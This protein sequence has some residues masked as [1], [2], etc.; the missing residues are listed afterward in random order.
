MQSWDTNSSVQYRV[1]EEPSAA[2]DLYKWNF[3]VTISNCLLEEIYT[4]G[5]Y[6]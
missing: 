1:L 3:Q 4:S 2:A 5:N 6:T